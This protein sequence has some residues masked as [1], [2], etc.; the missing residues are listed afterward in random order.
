MQQQH[1]QGKKECDGYNKNVGERYDRELNVILKEEIEEKNKNE[2]SGVERG[3][4]R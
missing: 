1:N 3:G 4:E 2:I